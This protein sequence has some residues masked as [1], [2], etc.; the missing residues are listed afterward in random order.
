VVG[1]EAYYVQLYVACEAVCVPRFKPAYGHQQGAVCM[2]S[3]VTAAQ[4]AHEISNATR[5]TRVH[6][7]RHAAIDFCRRPKALEEIA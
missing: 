1:Y 3:K 7:W 5:C 4:H 6:R 2:L